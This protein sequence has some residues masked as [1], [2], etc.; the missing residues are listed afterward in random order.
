MK[1]NS[2][3]ITIKEISE[4]LEFPTEQVRRYHLERIARLERG[5]YNRVDAYSYINKIRAKQGKKPL[6]EEPT[7]RITRLSVE[8]LTE[9]TSTFTIQVQGINAEDFIKRVNDMLEGA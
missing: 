8:E 2:N 1:L 4:L 3:G 5:I 9:R 6:S 7:A